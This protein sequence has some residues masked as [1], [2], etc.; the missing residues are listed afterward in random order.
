MHK[1]EQDGSSRYVTSILSEAVLCSSES[2]SVCIQSIVLISLDVALRLWQ[3]VY[4][5]YVSVVLAS[6][7]CTNKNRQTRQGRQ[8]Q[9]IWDHTLLHRCA[10]LLACMWRY[11]ACCYPALLHI[12]YSL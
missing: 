1:G 5:V 12:I 8:Q 10:C 9:V 4:V 7:S 2:C 3:L 6:T 11:D